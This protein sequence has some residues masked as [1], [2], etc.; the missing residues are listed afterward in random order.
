MGKVDVH[1]TEA[2]EVS[3]MFNAG[4]SGKHVNHSRYSKMEKGARMS[5]P[6]KHEDKYGEYTRIKR[7][8]GYSVQ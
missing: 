2:F 1:A 4:Q 3:A 5:V 8:E 7:E 6:Q